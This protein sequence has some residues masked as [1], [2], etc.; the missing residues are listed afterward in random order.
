MTD[1]SPCLLPGPELPISPRAGLCRPTNHK[2]QF[3][4]LSPAGTPPLR[5]VAMANV[6]VVVTSLKPLI[7]FMHDVI[8]MTTN[9][10][11]KGR[12]TQVGQVFNFL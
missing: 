2:L 8:V 1:I 3:D 11:L 6:Y 5:L 7:A 10:E 9:Q 4:S 12:P